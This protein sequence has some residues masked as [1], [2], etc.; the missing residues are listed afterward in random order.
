ME[1][2]Y[3]NSRIGWLVWVVYPFTV[4]CCMAGP[5]FT[6]TDVWLGLSLS[7]VFCACMLILMLSTKYAVR[8]SEFGVRNLYSWQWFPIGKIASIQQTNS[9]IASAALSTKRIAIRF[10]DPKVLR[11]YAALEISPKNQQ[12]FI[13]LLL[14]INPS[15]RVIF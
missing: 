2:K 6:G 1:T 7:V 4:V 9:I 11:S 12:E 10:S 5:I 8:G 15:I 3:F 13:A 14:Q